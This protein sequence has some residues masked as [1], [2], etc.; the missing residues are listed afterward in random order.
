V[1]KL[2]ESNIVVFGVVRNCA[3]GLTSEINRLRAALCQ[4]KQVFFF[5]VESDSSDNTVSI[6]KEI[7]ASV[8]RFSFLSLGKLADIYPKRTE[9]LALCR[10]V[11]IKELQAND[12]YA[13]CDH[14]IIADLDGVNK[15]LTADAIASCWTRDDW[16][17]CAANQDGYY[18]D[19]WAL[20][21]PLWS[22]NDYEEVKSF[23]RRA[24]VGRYQA[25]AAA[26]FSRMI[27]LNPASEWIRVDSAFGGLAIYKKNIL[28]GSSYCGLS[29]SG[30]EV[31]EHVA[32]HLNITRRG[33]RIYI[34]PALINARNVEHVRASIGG[35]KAIFRL[36]A[37]LADAVD[38][39][40]KYFCFISKQFL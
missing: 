3:R 20:R 5:I 2:C 10:N 36:R 32:L 16:D 26:L 29:S 25:Q 17:V 12:E 28:D 33:G 39:M 31:C 1:T 18:Y 14:V 8:P 38:W 37:C 11:Y 19:I 23:L 6:L 34:N 7:K 13:K 40:C 30:S 15:R 35:A 24:G 4:A 22:P 21:H 9:R 27:K